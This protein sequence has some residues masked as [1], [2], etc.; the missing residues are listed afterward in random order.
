MLKFCY[1]YYIITNSRGHVP[2][3][4]PK[5]IILNGKYKIERL[6]GAGVFGEVYLTTHLD[7]GVQRAIKVAYRSMPGFASARFEEAF[8]RFRQE[9][10]I[11]ARIKNEHIIQIHD[12]ENG[13]ESLHLVVVWKIS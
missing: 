8:D 4:Q 10:Q 1:N 13:E 6:L 7:L 3:Y 9:A 11:G 12:F 2:L 5:D